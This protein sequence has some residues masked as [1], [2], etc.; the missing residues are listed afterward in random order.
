MKKRTLVALVVAALSGFEALAFSAD[1]FY[2]VR[3]QEGKLAY[4]SGS[5]AEAADL[6]RIGCFGLLDQP[7]LL[8]EGLVWLS[9]AQNRLNRASDLEATLRRFLEVEKRF[10]PYAKAALP[11]ET[12]KEFEEVAARRLPPEAL[13]LVP[14][15]ARLVETEEQKL[16]KLVPRERRKAYE[17][18]AAA[19]PANAAWPLAVARTAMEL[20]QTK[21]AVQWAGRALEIDPANADARV[22]R[23]QALLARK[24]RAGA[25]A[26]FSALPPEVL[27]ASPA[28]RADRFV[29]LAAVKAW[30]PAREAAK[31]LPEE[32]LARPDVAAALKSLPA[33]PKAAP[34]KPADAGAAV[35]VATEAAALPGAAPAA[36]PAVVP[37]PP[38]A[39]GAGAAGAP[40]PGTGPA[41]TA[42]PPAP[43]PPAATDAPG[44]AAPG[45]AST[46]GAGTSGDGA[47]TPAAVPQESREARRAQLEAAC[48]VR[49][50]KAVVALAR[51]L[52]PFRDGEEPS[53]FYAA[54][55]LYETGK[56][57]EARV[58]M[59][60]A[61]PRIATTPFVNYYATRLLK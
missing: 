39:D 4:Q 48:M 3:L 55:G 17:A 58:L 43:G 44:A 47:P 26:D 13:K 51:A 10:A 54:V 36:E 61:K 22:V 6:L 14:V 25:L 57:D 9:L 24:D 50:W 35:G 37:A 33:E 46:A 23:I 16:A 41:G 12:R 45:T 15:L 34:E 18:R 8:S 27:E 31:G 19:E 49:D 32:L 38:A 42:G 2:R 60:R 30:E 28:L 11:E 21:D 7:V 59:E 56:K 20:G 52:E 1:D 5:T 53:M 29:A 40:A